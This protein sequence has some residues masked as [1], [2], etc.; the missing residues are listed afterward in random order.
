MDRDLVGRFKKRPKL[1]TAADVYSI[2][3]VVMT[4]RGNI[5]RPA[6]AKMAVGV[7][8]K[9]EIPNYSCLT[10]GFY[11]ESD[12]AAESRAEADSDAHY[13]SLHKPRELAECCHKYLNCGQ[14]VPA[15]L[16]TG[17][18]VRIKLPSSEHALPT[19]LD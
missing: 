8:A 4:G 14:E 13:E 17:L 1:E 3:N 18:K 9:I 7:A 15:I 6:I 19:L 12:D 5:A 10:V 16:R 2:A 11:A